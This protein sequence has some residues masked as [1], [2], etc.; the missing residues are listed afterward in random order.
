MFALLS[1]F[2]P[3]FIKIGNL[4]GAYVSLRGFL[5]YLK[6]KKAAKEGQ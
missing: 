6:A 3:L 2:L 5:S 1:R 4:L